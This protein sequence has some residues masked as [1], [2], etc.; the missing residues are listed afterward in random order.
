MNFTE[1]KE[2]CWKYTQ[3]QLKSFINKR[4]EPGIF[5]YIYINEDHHKYMVKSDI[6]SFIKKMDFIIVFPAD[7]R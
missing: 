4:E 7:H 5:H 1:L 2:F 3:N 6:N